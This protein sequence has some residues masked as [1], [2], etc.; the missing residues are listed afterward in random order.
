VARRR[1]GLSPERAGVFTIPSL[2]P[3]TRE[4]NLRHETLRNVT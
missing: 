3:T 1:R 2:I 4:R